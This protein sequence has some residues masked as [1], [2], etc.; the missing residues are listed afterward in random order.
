M[1]RLTHRI[2]LRIV[3]AV[4]IIEQ[5]YGSSLSVSSLAASTGLSVSRFEHLFRCY[6]SMSARVFILELRLFRATELLVDSTD[7]ISE[8]A[9]RVGI[10]D[11]SNFAH[12]FRRRFGISPSQFR[13]QNE[14]PWRVDSTLP[15]SPA[16]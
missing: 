16:S 7:R 13:R 12:E 14:S 3:T 1:N 4:Q 5:K 11:P 6:L 15:T 9:R 2:D 10:H 8:I